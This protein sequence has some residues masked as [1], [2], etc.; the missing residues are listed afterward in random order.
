MLAAILQTA[1]YKTGLY[2]SPHLKEFTERIKID[3]RE[4]PH[5]FVVDFVNRMKPELEKIQPSFFETTVAMAFDFFARERVDVAV[6]EVGLGGRLDSTNVITPEVSL[7]T[8]IS[9]DH[10]NL[11]GDTLPKIAGE[12]AGIIKPRVPVIV[13]ERQPE[14][15]SVFMDK[16]QQEQSPI[17]FDRHTRPLFRRGFGHSAARTNGVV[18]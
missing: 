10:A 14:V 1:G 5:D 15:E 2:T 12:K 4:V 11:L 18:T 9:W 13:S 17:V 8:N 6:I 7:I 3:G 16:A